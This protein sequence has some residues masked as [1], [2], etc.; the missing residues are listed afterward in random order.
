MKK[1]FAAALIAA[2]AL[3]DASDHWAIIVA[4]SNGFWNYRHQADAHHAWEVVTKNG[5]PKENVILFAY[6][7]IANN[8]MNPILGSIFNKPNGNNVYNSEAIDYRGDAVTPENFLKVLTG[9]ST[10]GGNGKVLKSTS[11]SKVFVFFTD[12]GAPGFIAFPSAYLYA[13]QLNEAV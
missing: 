13:D 9:D 4:G 11:A 10:T 6:D 1:T 5:I 8:S 7:D 3:A 2:S 12:H